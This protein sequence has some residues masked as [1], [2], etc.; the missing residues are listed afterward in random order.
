ME[1][2]WTRFSSARRNSTGKADAAGGT[3]RRR[4]PSRPGNTRPA[5]KFRLSDYAYPWPIL[6]LYLSLG[7]TMLLPR[8]KLEDIQAWKLR[9]LIEHAYRHV[10]YYRELFRRKGLEPEDIRSVEDLSKVP[11]L[12]KSMVREHHDDLTADNSRKFSPYVN[13]TSGSTGTPLRFIQDRNVSIARFAFFLRVW[14]IAGYRPWM[15]WAQM[16]GMYVPGKG[17]PVWRYCPSLNSLQISAPAMKDSDCGLVL[18]ELERFKPRILRGYASSLYTLASHAHRHRI[19]VG[20]RLKSI[21]TGAETLEDYQRRLMQE[22]FG[23]PVFDI[24]SSWEAVCLIYECRAHTMH[25]FM[26]F[27]VME[28]LD[29]NDRP[30]PPG[31]VGEITAT[32]FFNHS[33]PFIRYK[34]GDLACLSENGCTCGTGHPVVGRILGRKDDAL[35]DTTGSLVPFHGFLMGTLTSYRGLEGLHQTQ[36]V[37]NSQDCVEV[38]LVVPDR[39]RL[40]SIKAEME[41]SI[42][43]RLGEDMNIRFIETDDIPR[44]ANGKSRFVK[45]NLLRDRGVPD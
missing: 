8:E 19:P 4:D 39:S 26:E 5:M 21:V 44:E 9:R 34:T 2:S 38:Y 7:R 10:P 28:L 45:N 14:R 42:R 11:V 18:D 22:V 12:T 6:R 43:E 20:F 32:S 13:T 37:Q 30:V 17:D 36:I 29:G 27:S 41:S 31:E 35:F 25:Q 1:C 15:R 16:D 33:M 24:Y 40:V 3:F 23:A